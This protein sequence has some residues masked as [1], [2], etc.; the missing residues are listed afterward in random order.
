MPPHQKKLPH[1][2]GRFGPKVSWYCSC[3]SC[4]QLGEYKWIFGNR[5]HRNGLTFYGRLFNVTLRSTE[6]SSSSGDPSSTVR[7]VIFSRPKP[8]QIA[9]YR[10]GGI[11]TP[12][13]NYMVLWP[14]SISV[15]ARLSGMWEDR[16]SLTET[17]GCATYVAV[18]HISGEWFQ[19]DTSR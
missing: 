4:Y 13:D 12:S 6:V 15:L 17:T 19:R 8:P 2:W 1:I 18:G 11:W 16:Q 14:N 9:P 10:G 5:P 7:T 3:L